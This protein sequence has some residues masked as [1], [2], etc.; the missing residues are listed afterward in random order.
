VQGLFTSFLVLAEPSRPYATR[1][2]NGAAP[3][4]A[5]DREHGVASTAGLEGKSS[6]QGLG[7]QTQE[8]RYR[9]DMLVLRAAQD[10]QAAMARPL[11][12]L[13]PCGLGIRHGP[14][15]G[16]SPANRASTASVQVG[17]A[18]PALPGAVRADCPA[19]L[20][21][22]PAAVSRAI[23]VERYAGRDEPTR[24]AAST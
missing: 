9:A 18:H 11:R 19:P 24:V 23:R 16:Q 5:P 8:S 7:F 2:T 12:N 13:T 4:D 17:R 1:R 14:S 15:R 10:G 20:H 22:L 3:R 21:L 6:N